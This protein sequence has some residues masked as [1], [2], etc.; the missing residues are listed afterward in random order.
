MSQNLTQNEANQLEI[1]TLGCGCFWCSEAVYTLVK[2]VTSVVSGYAGG[3][4]KNPTYE[5]VSMGT[6]GHAEVVQVTFNP[7]IITYQEILEIF[8]GTH[9]PTTLN[10]QGPDVGT[11]YRSI[12]L[13][14]SDMQ[15]EIAEDY[16]ANLNAS[17]EYKSPIV[18]TVESF[19]IFYEAEDY[20]KNYFE[21]HPEQQYCRVIIAPK[22]AKFHKYFGVRL[23]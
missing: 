22:I 8:F 9:D 13:Y 20:H 11:Q 18:T 6:T 5:Q 19:E 3:K 12:I 15:K 4:T 21:K 14:H 10:R 1:A 2:G 7:K 17:G 23:K 16:I